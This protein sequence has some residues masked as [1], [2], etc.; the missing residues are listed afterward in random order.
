MVRESSGEITIGV[1][2]MNRY[3]PRAERIKVPPSPPS[4]QRVQTKKKPPGDLAILPQCASLRGKG[5][6]RKIGTSRRYEPEP[7]GLRAMTALVVLREKVRTIQCRSI[8]ITNI[9][10]SACETRL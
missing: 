1:S 6:V 8:G 2:Q 9:S 4:A 5:M 7:D 3:S 10:G